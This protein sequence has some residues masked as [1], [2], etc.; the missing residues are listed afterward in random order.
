ML[1][2]FKTLLFQL[3]P[4]SNSCYADDSSG[5]LISISLPMTLDA[6]ITSITHKFTVLIKIRMYARSDC[7]SPSCLSFKLCKIYIS[8]PSRGHIQFSS[9]HPFKNFT[10]SKPLHIPQVNEILELVDY[11][12]SVLLHAFL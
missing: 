1:I 3:Q 10:T 4:E 5:N 6:S 9:Y 8:S 11:H 2:L 12:L 7:D